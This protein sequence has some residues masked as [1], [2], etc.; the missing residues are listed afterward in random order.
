MFS[1]GAN[2]HRPTH[3]LSVQGRSGVLPPHA[4]VSGRSSDMIMSAAYFAIGFAPITA[5]A[6]SLVGLLPLTVSAWAVV[7]PAAGLGLLLG[8]RFPGYG[9]LALKGFGI[10]IVAVTVYDCTRA[11]FIVLGIWGDFIPNIGKWLLGSPQPNWL[12]GYLYR[13]VGDGGGMGMAFTVVYSLLRPHLRCWLVAIGYGLAIWG[14]L[15]LTLLLAPDGQELMFRLTPISVTLS[16]LGHVVY[17]TTI[18]VLLT[19]LLRR[20]QR[21]EQTG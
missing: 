19:R 12:V 5:L 9:A 10:G 21:P 11:P 15:M 2:L 7:A 8:V 1:H 18:G 3:M 16:L 17:G 13:Y 6:I 14:C 20:S 4:L